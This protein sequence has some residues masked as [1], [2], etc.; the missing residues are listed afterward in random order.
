MHYNGEMDNQG[1]IN[2][3]IKTDEIDS[4]P[5][6]E[7]LSA[8]YL[9]DVAGFDYLSGTID[10]K[11]LASPKTIG[12]LYRDGDLN[13]KNTGSQTAVQLEGT[14]YVT[15]DLVFQQPGGPKA[16][17]IDLNG[18]TIYVEGSITFP[19]QRVTLAGSGCIIA[20]GDIDFHPGISSEDGDFIFVMSLEGEVR[21]SPQADFHGSVAGSINVNLQPNSTLEHEEPPDELN[22]PGYDSSG[23][24][25]SELEIRT[26]NIT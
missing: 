4:W 13:I 19:A 12:P 7:Q 15:G 5:T 26:W 1:T 11:D 23:S 20:V 9:A 21:F 18:Q 8:F 22:F 2:G 10:L 16:Y 14:V 3:E 6:A 25:G 17:T 24:S